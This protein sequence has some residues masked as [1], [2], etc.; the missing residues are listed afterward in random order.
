MKKF[1]LTFVLLISSIFLFAQDYPIMSVDSCGNKVVTLTLE[2]AQKIDNNLEI[3]KLLK[4]Q[5]S[6]CDSVI[7]AYIVV[8]DEFR[9]KVAVLEFSVKTLNDQ[10]KSKDRALSNLQEQLKN[11]KKDKT[12]C[13]GQLKSKDIIIDDR[14]KEI[15]K[16]K[17]QKIVGF[18][19]GT[20]ALIVSVVLLLKSL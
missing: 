4:I 11:E 13:E 14:D 3:L 18:A 5:T 17:I 20:A 7:S 9:N 16:L 1:I 2:Q 15:R 8:V 19:T 6:D 10:L 12:L